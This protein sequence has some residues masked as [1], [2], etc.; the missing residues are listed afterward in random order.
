MVRARTHRQ[1]ELDASDATAT[2]FRGIS[3]E[4]VNKLAG[5]TYWRPVGPTEQDDV[6]ADGQ[7]T[8][9]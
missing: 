7:R 8:L 6:A 4:R 3:A 1:H 9:K 5:D 2:R